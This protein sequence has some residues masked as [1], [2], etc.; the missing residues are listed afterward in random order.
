V[1][2]TITVRAGGTVRF[3]NADATKHTATARDPAARRAFDSGGLAR[4][5][6]RTITFARDGHYAYYCAYHPFMHGTVVVVGP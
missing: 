1:P 2:A 4:G 6:S 5:R 3:T